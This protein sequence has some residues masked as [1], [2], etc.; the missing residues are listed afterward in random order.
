M[1][2]FFCFCEYF[3]FQKG[4]WDFH[5]IDVSVVADAARGKELPKRF[6]EKLAGILAYYGEF[7]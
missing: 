7:H 4:K 3:C 2:I 1:Q 5:V 6:M